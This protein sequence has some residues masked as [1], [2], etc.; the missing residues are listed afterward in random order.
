MF[1]VKTSPLT[2]HIFLILPSTVSFSF[3][4]DCLI[5]TTSY[6]T[7][8]RG[9]IYDPKGVL[10]FK[11][12]VKFYPLARNLPTKIV[13]NESRTKLNETITDFRRLTHKKCTVY[14]LIFSIFG[15]TNP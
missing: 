15:N 14:T 7:G 1:R 8:G 12:V 11:T 5:K 13:E 4:K 10:N 2:L 3:C 6:T 9:F